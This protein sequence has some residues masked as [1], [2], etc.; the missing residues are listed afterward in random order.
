MKAVKTITIPIA[1]LSKRKRSVLEQLMRVY[2]EI[3]E[4]AVN[5]A[6]SNNITSRKRLH[7]E[8]YDKIRSKHQRLP[9]HYIYTAF[10]MSLG[11]VK[12][13]RKR[14]RKG[15][16]KKEK[17]EVSKLNA[18]MLDDYHLFRISGRSLRISTESGHI[19]LPLKPTKY[20]EA[21][22]P[23][24]KQGCLLIKK[25]DGFFLNAVIRREVD[26][27][28]PEGIMAYD[29][30]EKSIDALM[31]RHDKAEWIHIDISEAKHIHQ[32]YQKI[33]ERK[34]RYLRGRA[35]ARVDQILHVA[36]KFL[37]ERARDMKVA[38]VTEDIKGINRE[39]NKKGKS[40]RR[41]MNLWCYGRIRFQINYKARWLGVPLLKDVKA[42]GNSKSCPVCGEMR[43]RRGWVFKCRKCGIEASSHL[44][45]CIN[46][47]KKASDEASRI[48][49]SPKAL[50]SLSPKWFVA[51][52][53]GIRDVREN[54]QYKQL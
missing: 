43:T 29:V 23:S 33:R 44:I 39:I 22:L 7:E 48:P 30:N 53:K 32:R 5:Y 46:I 35:K 38:L 13:F 9:S 36:T 19:Y 52:V 18:V 11:I 45:A 49:F 12:S 3:V 42:R 25:G 31:V 20:Q 6:W 28:K 21:F 54:F 4:E 14:V 51:T 15:L 17:P 41:R 50:V 10:T 27:L 24:I 34:R 47:L 26:E 37:V 2:R 16:T 40:F 8:L 1:E